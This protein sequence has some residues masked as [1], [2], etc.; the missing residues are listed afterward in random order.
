MSAPWVAVA[1][2]TG[3]FVGVTWRESYE[4]LIGR[5]QPMLILKRALN[6]RVEALAAALIISLVL[7]MIVGV[8][9]VLN[10]RGQDRAEACQVEFNRL[11]AEARDAR[12]GPSESS[13]DAQIDDVLQDLTYQRGLLKTI[14]SENQTVDDLA[15]I[16]KA[17]IDSGMEYLKTL[18]KV[19]KVRVENEYPPADYC[20][21]SSR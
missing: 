19:Q 10:E 18:R 1:F 17:R 13:T 9:I 16:I 5:H 15:G 8:G 14:T 4:I 11:T 6:V 20:S 12:I 7:N 21:R 2:L 3:V